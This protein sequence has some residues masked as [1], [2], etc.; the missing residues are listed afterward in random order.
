MMFQVFEHA[1]FGVFFVRFKRMMIRTGL[2]LLALVA[3]VLLLL[4]TCSV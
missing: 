3:G 2:I 1:C 4:R